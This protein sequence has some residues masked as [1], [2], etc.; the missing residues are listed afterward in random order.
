[1]CDYV[2]DSVS[3]DF[4][5]FFFKFPFRLHFH[6]LFKQT[7][8]PRFIKM[9]ET[10]KIPDTPEREQRHSESDDTEHEVQFTPIVSLPEV[11]VSTNEEDEVEFLKLRA[12]LYRFDSRSDTPEWKERG[13]GVL[14]IL[15]HK[16]KSSFR[17][18]MR[19]DKTLKVCANHF[20]T[21]W[22][23]LKDSVTN[24]KAFIYTVMADFAD[25]E[26]KSE[27]LAVKFATHDN[28]ALFKSKFGDAQE[29]LKTDCDLYNGKV[30]EEI[31][32]EIEKI[33]EASEENE[34]ED[35]TK[36]ISEKLS[37]LDVDKKKIESDV[38][39]VDQ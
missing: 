6:W 35:D 10:I 20:I 37:Q 1:M 16:E 29:I 38:K 33:L 19:R 36:E 27:C 4:Q 31:Q 32:K 17:V 5:R 28:A 15:R 34:D 3:E 8:I 21:P 26:A 25:E 14:K 24:E 2:F 7:E 39:V 13:T 30:E 18:V 23:N 9:S 12:K 11:H 22:M